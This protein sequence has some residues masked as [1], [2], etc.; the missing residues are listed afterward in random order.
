MFYTKI[1]RPSINLTIKKLLHT[2][3]FSSAKLP[4]RRPCR[5]DTGVRETTAT[6][7]VKLHWPSR[8]LRTVAYDGI[9]KTRRGPATLSSLRQEFNSYQSTVWTNTNIH[10]SWFNQRLCLRRCHV[11]KFF[12][13]EIVFRNIIALRLPTHITCPM[14]VIGIF[15]RQIPSCLARNNCR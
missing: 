5:G 6:Q 15:M 8:V 14:I 4:D 1:T 7:T 11:N 12:T 9:C 3:I 13:C 2:E 10:M